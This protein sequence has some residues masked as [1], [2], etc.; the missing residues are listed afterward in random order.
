MTRRSTGW[1]RDSLSLGMSATLLCSLAAFGQQHSIRRPDGSRVEG[2]RIDARLN[3]LMQ[4][5]HVTG[6]GIA[7]FH[8]GKIEYIKALGSRD[9]DKG[10]PLTTNSAMSAASLSKAAFA[11]LV[12]RL[13]QERVLDLD[14]PVSFPHWQLRPLRSTAGSG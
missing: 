11:T 13:V 7:I 4:A 5:A 2:S 9:T 1:G 12:M 14:K 10:L 8:D 3:Q 6:A